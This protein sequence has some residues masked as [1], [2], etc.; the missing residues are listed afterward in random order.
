M[1]HRHR[2][3]GL[4]CTPIKSSGGH[5]TPAAAASAGGETVTTQPQ[6]QQHTQQPQSGYAN[7]PVVPPQPIYSAPHQEYYPQQVPQQAPSPLSAHDT[8]NSIQQ[9]NIQHHQVTPL[10]GQGI[11]EVHGKSGHFQGPYETHG[12]SAQQPAQ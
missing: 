2:K 11:Y 6:M 10:P 12:H 7:Q 9:Q 5:D 4:H 1:L 8:G 3:A